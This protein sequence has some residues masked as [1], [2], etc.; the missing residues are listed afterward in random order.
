M[1]KIKI[2]L[3][4]LLTL[5]WIFNGLNEEKKTVWIC[6]LKIV[7]NFSILF[8]LLTTSLTRFVCLSVDLYR[9]RP[10]L[11]LFNTFLVKRGYIF[12]DTFW[13]MHVR[14]PTLDRTIQ[15][16]HFYRLYMTNMTQKSILKKN[17]V[18]VYLIMCCSVYW[19]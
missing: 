4:T 16:K 2:T 9:V 7:L 19:Q 5:L 11:C 10:S 12:F 17:H 13:T 14:L 3:K 18:H 8:L 15:T 1:L 6:P